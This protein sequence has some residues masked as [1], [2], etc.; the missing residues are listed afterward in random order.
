MI[1]KSKDGM[2]R[3]DEEA[4][5]SEFAAKGMILLQGCEDG[6]EGVLPVGM[7]AMDHTL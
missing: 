6:G 2:E 1:G 4:C 7:A 5:K 3:R